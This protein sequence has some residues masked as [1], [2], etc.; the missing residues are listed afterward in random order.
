MKR[1]IFSIIISLCGI[2]LFAQPQTVNVGTGPNAGDGD[3]LRTAFQKVN[4]NDVAAFDSLGDHRTAINLHWAEI[5]QKLE[6]NMMDS[7]K[8]GYLPTS[9][10]TR[11]LGFSHTKSVYVDSS[12]N[13]S[14]MTRWKERPSLKESIDTVNGEF[15]FYTF[16]KDGLHEWRGIE[17]IP[18][19]GMQIQAIV[20]FAEYNRLKLY[21]YSLRVE[22]LE[23]KVEELMNQKTGMRPV[24]KLYIGF[25][26]FLGILCL[27]VAI[28]NR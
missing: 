22:S 24:D 9:N 1:V 13:A 12:S 11:W 23:K 27:V 20:A 26:I 25:I 7:L 10:K 19:L 2:L 8:L 5:I 21:D 17:D 3:N 18:S 14:F 16:D 6:N 4:T 15:L 28:Y